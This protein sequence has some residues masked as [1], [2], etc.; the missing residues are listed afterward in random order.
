MLR[1]EQL[2]LPFADISNLMHFRHMQAR[3]GGITAFGF[4]SNDVPTH[5]VHNATGTSLGIRSNSP[6]TEAA[7]EFVRLSLLPSASRGVSFPLRIDLFEQLIYEQLSHTELGYA[8]FNGVTFELP[9]MTESDADLLR[10]LILNIGHTLIIEH[11]VQNIVN[12]DVPAFF[13]GTRSA[14]DTARII[15]SRVQRL[16]AERGR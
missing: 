15:Q 10:E 4:P 16:L 14:E 12:E 9:I 13:A 2:L 7:W 5:A 6:H 3:L 11:P 1:D 8:H